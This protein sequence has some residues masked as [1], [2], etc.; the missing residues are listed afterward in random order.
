[1]SIKNESKQ[2]QRALMSW[3]SKGPVDALNVSEYSKL[4]KSYK[5]QMMLKILQER[6]LIN[7]QTMRAKER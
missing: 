6:D 1:M 3:M 7:E 2:L 4:L 5:E